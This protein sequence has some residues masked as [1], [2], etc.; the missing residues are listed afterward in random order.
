VNEENRCAQCGAELAANAPRGLCPACLLKGGLGTET[1]PSAGG[2]SAAAADY[3]PPTPAE[4]SPLFP[5]LEI[6]ELVGRGG[7]GVVYKARQK[8][9]DRL[10]A[11]KI[12]A[13]KI[14]QDPAFAE[15]FQREAQA[16]AM[17]SHPQIVAVHD[18]GQTGGLYYFLMEFV[19][20]LNLRRLLDAG[21]LSPETA[22]TIVPQIC[23]ALQYA[24]DHGVVH[25]D[26]KPENVLVDKEGRVKIAD[27]GIAKLVGRD[28]A[29]PCRSPLP[30]GEGQGEGVAGPG[31]ISPLTVAGQIIGTP[32][33]MAPEQIEHP[34]QVDHRA[35]IYSLGVVFYQMLT[36][37]LPIGRF[38]APSKKVQIDVR[39]DEVVLR[40]L[41]KEPE[42]RY[43][44]AS[45]IKTQVE[46]IVTTPNASGE[47]AG[48]ATGASSPSK[49][50]L[51]YISTPEYLRSFRGRF[52][53][54]YQGKGELRLD[55]QSLSFHS[56]WPAVVIPLSAIRKIAQGDYPY[57]AKPAP[58]HFIEV[59]FTERG[60]ERTLLFTPVLREV[61]FPQEANKVVAEWLSALLEAVQ[62]RTGRRLSVGESQVAQ[63]KLW[64][65]KT[66][67]LTAVEL[68]VICS[69]IPAILLHQM[70]SLLTVLLVGSISAIVMTAMLLAMRW[71]PRRSAIASGNLDSLTMRGSI[72]VAHITRPF[73][74]PG[75]TAGKWLAL[76]TITAMAVGMLVS[77]LLSYLNVTP[78][79]QATTPVAE[80]L[81]EYRRTLIGYDLG[82]DSVFPQRKWT[83]YD[84]T[85]LEM[86]PSKDAWPHVLGHVDTN[87]NA[88]KVVGNES[89]FPH[90]PLAGPNAFM[91]PLDRGLV[92]DSANVTLLFLKGI[93]PK[94]TVVAK[95]Y[96]SLVCLGPME[97]RLNF[98][99]Y[100][101]A[102]V[103]G[104]LPGQIT[105]Q[106][107]CDLVVAGKF[108]GRIFADSYAMIYLVGGCTGNVELR[109]GAKLYI[110]GRTA[111]ASLS[112]IKGQGNVFLEDSDLPLGEHR[113]DDLMV[114]VGK[115]AGSAPNSPVAGHGGSQANF[116]ARI[117]DDPAKAVPTTQNVLRNSGIETGDTSPDGWQ[118]GAAIEGVTYSW[119]KKV[120]FEGKASL[121]IEKTAQRYFPIAQ[122][123]QTVGRRSGPPA[124]Q[125][126]AQVKAENMTKAILDVVFLD[127]QGNWL[128]HQ[129]AAYIGSQEQG[130]PPANHDWRLYSGKVDIPPRTKKLCVGL[131]VYGPGKVW[132]DDVRAGYADA[133]GNGV[134]AP[135][136]QP[137]TAE[138]PAT[139]RE[140]AAELSQQGWLLWRQG[141]VD[142]A[143]AKFSAAAKLEPKDANVLNGLGWA[144]F[145]SNRQVAEKAFQQAIALNPD[146]GG[147]LNG[148]GQLYLAQRKYDLA[149]KYLLKASPD[150]SAAW[151][152]LT[153][154]YL[155]QGKF[156]EAEKWAQKLVDS[157]EKDED[158][159]RLLQAA[160]EKRLN[161]ELR[162][163]IEPPPPKLE[164]L[165]QEGWRLFFQKNRCDEAAAKFSEVLT[166]D[167]N[168]ANAWNGLGWASFNGGKL[169]AAEKAL[170]RAVELAPQHWGAV[171]GLG[172]LYLKQKKY[173][174]AEKYLLQAAP[175]APGAWWG[176][177]KLYLAQGKF[178][179][180]EKWARKAVDSPDVNDEAR[181]LLEA[182]KKKRLPDDLRRN[183]E[184]P[185]VK[186]TP[187]K[188]TP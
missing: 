130:Q 99:S 77:L 156:A 187:A 172:Q 145:G 182:A 89:E 176:L 51:C 159:R 87:P 65:A 101:T 31:P 102:L 55:S 133:S 85:R 173:D 181:R 121:C 129:W 93:A 72:G 143:I 81:E 127:E 124:L 5:D 3:M 39:L 152:G 100:A 134:P 57:S 80:A 74:R 42:R 64:L 115:N 29:E 88:F 108:S 50:S 184:P 14:G 167:P 103:K 21:K 110:A 158:T 186:S 135:P 117:G 10:V 128:S 120:A 149:E 180:A 116:S 141:Q 90:N 7:M 83:H 157:G 148:L 30:P 41:E 107:Y 94:G 139:S 98:D 114:T 95:T 119:D 22:L 70:P 164:G 34:L 155:L 69:V 52:L 113:I 82:F 33:Y 78:S 140:T 60:V 18:F 106:S 68:T 62:V 96:A 49:V 174:L 20:G 11:L 17:L 61:A 76:V 6:V 111:K 4:L 71:W 54:I 168:D 73:A 28:A 67:L 27:F 123:S 142:R 13:P 126:S 105:S 36:G 161:K 44:Q 137:A 24:H 179:E 177:A 16:M 136:E 75:L 162:S 43:Q 79:R 178:A 150:A 160:K 125:V 25:R 138:A 165:S 23:D 12:L 53:W 104:D 188:G 183:I 92:A 175:E 46:S 185:K 132:F 144:S 56:D 32:Q 118:E 48:R 151:Y 171:N 38:A 91:L 8:R 112:R 97:G 26:I 147:A 66:V 166:L 1:G 15:R 109:H 2:A 40:A 63:D 163:A 169:P 45:E 84:A 35:D 59:T 153:R 47:F 86:Y 9:L 37:E 146:H 154:V 170:L 58:I 131:Q 19:D 122:W